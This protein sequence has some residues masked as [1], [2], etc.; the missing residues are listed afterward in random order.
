MKQGGEKPMTAARAIGLQHIDELLHFRLYVGESDERVEFGE[1][2]WQRP[3]ARR[4]ARVRYAAGSALGLRAPQPPARDA[5]ATNEYNPGIG[6][7]QQ[8]QS[9]EEYESDHNAEHAP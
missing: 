6:A 5:N 3:D 1:N 8:Q 4:A 7:K 9:A 2:L